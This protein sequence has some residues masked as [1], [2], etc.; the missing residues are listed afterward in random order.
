MDTAFRR[1]LFGFP[2][3]IRFPLDLHEE[4]ETRF[5]TRLRSGTHLST[6]MFPWVREIRGTSISSAFE[7]SASSNAR[8]SSMP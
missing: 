7:D 6:S 5:P 8:I 3:P 4:K 2:I 1:Q